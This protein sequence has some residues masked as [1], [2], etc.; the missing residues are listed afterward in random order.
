MSTTFSWTYEGKDEQHAMAAVCRQHAHSGDDVYDDELGK[1]VL[2]AMKGA[3]LMIEFRYAPLLRIKERPAKF[4]YVVN[5]RPAPA[6]VKPTG[7]SGSGMTHIGVLFGSSA[8]AGKVT[9]KARAPRGGVTILKMGASDRAAYKHEKYEEKKAVRLAA[10][11]SNHNTHPL[12]S[13]HQRA[14][15]FFLT[16]HAHD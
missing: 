3:N 15:Q 7:R 6:A 13:L 2:V 8:D 14:R 12:A 10:L 4:V 1:G 11:R 9:P 16:T 5:N